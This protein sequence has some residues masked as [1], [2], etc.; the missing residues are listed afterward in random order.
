[1]KLNRRSTRWLQA[2]VSAAVFSGFAIPFGMWLARQPRHGLDRYP[3]SISGRFAHDSGQQGGSRSPRG[4]APGAWQTAT[5]QLGNEVLYYVMVDR[6]AD[7]DPGNN[8]PTIPDSIPPIRGS[9][10]SSNGSPTR[11]TTPTTVCLAC[12]L[13]ATCRG[14]A[15]GWLI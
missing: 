7:G 12:S 11:A 13:G 9:G 10:R 8:T 15:I 14:Y 5:G 3:T 4:V 1:M 6:F 2:L